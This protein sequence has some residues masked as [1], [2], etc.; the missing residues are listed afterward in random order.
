MQQ[1]AYASVRVFVYCLVVSCVCVCT[2]H[3]AMENVKNIY[4][5]FHCI[6]KERKATFTTYTL[7]LLHLCTCAE[8]VLLYINLCVCMSVVVV[9]ISYSYAIPFCAFTTA[10]NNVNRDVY[11]HMQALVSYP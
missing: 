8:H 1:L 9:R 3:G 6:R 4:F 7:G 11:V 2:V 5:L 10:R